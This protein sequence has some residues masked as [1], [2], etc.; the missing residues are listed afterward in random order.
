[1]ARRIDGA[2][3]L[4]LFALF[5]NSLGARKAASLTL[6]ASQIQTLPVEAS[7]PEIIK[8]VSQTPSGSPERLIIPSINL[9]SPIVGLGLNNKGEMD[10]TSGRTNKVGWYKDGVLPGLT[11]SAVLDAH[12]F[13]AFKNLDKVKPGDDIYVY[14]STGQKLHFV[15]DAAKTYA[16][17][18]LSSTTLFGNRGTKGLNL[19]TCAGS[20][21][22]DRSTYD[23]RLIVF[24]NFVGIDS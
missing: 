13:A 22:A 24:T 12:V 11:G 2:I 4:I 14:T 7:V 19:I 21:T 8:V 18:K 6:P 17:N 1:M 15:A 20:L 5:F 9:D 3:A 16:L 23:H 10:V